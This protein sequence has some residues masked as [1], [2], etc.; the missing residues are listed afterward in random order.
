MH[1]L[2]M[3]QG[4]L[5]IKYVC[6]MCDEEIQRSPEGE[7]E[8]FILQDGRILCTSQKCA[9]AIRRKPS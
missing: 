1:R 2:K 5:D 9:D 7:L 8:L 3:T 6:C 4:T